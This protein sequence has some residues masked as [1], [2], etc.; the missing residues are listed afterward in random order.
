MTKTK[1]RSLIREIIES[2]IDDEVDVI[3][4]NIKTGHSIDFDTVCPRKDFCKFNEM[5]EEK[6]EEFLNNIESNTPETKHVFLRSFEKAKKDGLLKTCSYCYV[7][8]GRKIRDI[9]ANFKQF[10]PEHEKADYAKGSLKNISLWPKS[11]IDAENK[12]GG[13]ENFFKF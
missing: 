7:E 4:K 9:N 13:D 11:K 5:G 3:G 2:V 12:K 8:K 10:K 6:K 1:I